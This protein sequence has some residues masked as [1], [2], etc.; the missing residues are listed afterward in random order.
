MHVAGS[1]GAPTTRA[2]EL[3]KP[4]VGQGSRVKLDSGKRRVFALF[5]P[6]C[7]FAPCQCCSAAGEERGDEGCL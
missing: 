6:G 4:A 5:G 7:G 3:Q 1:A 2:P